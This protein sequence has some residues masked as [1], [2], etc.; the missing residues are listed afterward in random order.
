MGTG[1][2][3][4]CYFCNVEL[5]TKEDDVHTDPETGEDCCADCCP[6]C[7]PE[8]YKLTLEDFLVS[9]PLSCLI[10]G[11]NGYRIHYSH[12]EK[13][14]VAKNK[15]YETR[16]TNLDQLMK[17]V[18]KLLATQKKRKNSFSKQKGK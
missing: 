2:I 1:M 17:T 9:H 14:W 15:G 5:D 18:L 16:T 7:N 10:T 3:T 12:E 8:Q 6:E 11:H 13:C 4:S